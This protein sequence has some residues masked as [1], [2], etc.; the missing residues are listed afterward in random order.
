M[1]KIRELVTFW[2][3]APGECFFVER[4]IDLMDGKAL[5]GRRMEVVNVYDYDVEQEPPL[6]IYENEDVRIEYIRQKGP[7]SI[8]W[9]R[10][11]DQD[12]CSFQVNG[13]R[14]LRT[15]VGTVEL[16]P[17]DCTVIPRGVAHDNEGDPVG[18]HI[19]IYTRKPLRRAVPLKGEK[20]PP[21]PP[22]L[23]PGLGELFAQLNEGK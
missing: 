13:K 14:I 15:E 23:Y 2:D 19:I 8:G 17:G 5:G 9:H 4:E 11:C 21:K 16:K 1:G 22:D 10:G 7:Q 3:N 6:L 12:E 20:D 18:E